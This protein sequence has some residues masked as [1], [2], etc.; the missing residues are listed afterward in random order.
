VLY[1]NGS[2]WVVNH[3]GTPTGTLDSTSFTG[4]V[5]DFSEGGIIKTRFFLNSEIFNTSNLVSVEG[6]SIKIRGMDYAS[7]GFVVKYHAGGNKIIEIMKDVN[8]QAGLNAFTDTIVFEKGTRLWK[9]ALCYEFSETVTFVYLGEGNTLAPNKAVANWAPFINTDVTAADVTKISNYNTEIRV[10]FTSGILKN[11]YYG[12]TILDASTG[13]PIING[14]EASIDSGYSYG[15]NH[16]LL[17][18]LNS[19]GQNSGDTLIIPAGSV[20][21][22]TQGSI[23]FTEEIRAVYTGDSNWTFDTNLGT[24]DVD[25]IA[26]V[27]NNGDTEVRVQIPLEFSDT[28]YG[29]LF[30]DGEAYVAK[31][32]DGSTVSAASLFWYGGQSTGY[33]N[34]DHSLIGF[35]GI[36]GETA[37]DQFI[38]PAGTKL[39]ILNGSGYHTFSEDVVYTFL[40]G[41]WK[42][43]DLI[44]TVKTTAEHATVE[45]PETDMFAGREYTFTVAPESGYVISTVTANG[46]ELALVDGK[47]TFTAKGGENNIVVTAKKLYTVTVN[48]GNATV[49]GI[50]NG[51]YADGTTVNFTVS[52]STGYHV[53]SVSGATGSN[54]S[55]TVT[56]SGD[57]TITVNTEIN[58]YT[59]TVSA[60]GASVSGVSNNQTITHGQTYTFTTSVN[61]GYQLTSVTINGVEQGTS[62]SYSFTANGATSIVVTTKKLYAVTWSN[63]T[64]ATISVTANGNTISSGTTVVEGTSISVSVAANSGYTVTNVTANGTSIG[65]TSGTYTVNG[66]TTIAATVKK[67]YTVTASTSGGV[68]V[69]ATSKTVVEGESATFTLTVPTDATI[70]ANGT[71]ISGTSYT[72]SNV[73][74]NTTV[75]FTTWYTVSVTSL[76]N[77]SVT[78]DGTS[79]SQGWSELRESGTSITVQASY[80]QSNSRSLKVGSNSWSDTSAH[81]VT[82]SGKTDISAS[83]SG[84]CIVEGTM[85]MMA[86]GTQK[87]VEDLV[88]GDMLLV[89]NHYTGKYDARPLAINAHADE[90]A[91][92]YKIVNVNFSNGTQWRIAGTHGI[93]D[94]T[95]NEYV[96]ISAENI[97]E[98]I[99]HEF[100]YT[101]GVAGE[102]VTLTDYYVTEE[103]VKIY[104]PATVEFANY[105]ANGLLNAPPFPATYT[106]GQMNYFDF[107]ENMMYMNVQEDIERYGLYTYEDF[108]DYIS[109][110]VF[111]A[112]PFKY[113]KI[114]VEKGIMAW[115]DVMAVIEML[116]A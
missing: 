100:Y 85:I 27:Y 69:D 99:G 59:V 18:I 74:A 58:T 1:F 29:S 73:T 110:D 5:I 90:D 104:S 28:Y 91:K 38:I 6:G 13:L 33:P 32:A 82:I 101:N 77:A 80:T 115:E 87:A 97:D 70:K 96:M 83:S 2:Y 57:T 108:A 17:G 93:F 22:T 35:R 67:T 40:N 26:G 39:F 68:S 10:Q 63:P 50:A 111:N 60:T 36:I 49:S 88:V 92:L 89:F 43:G 42:A 3:D 103:F 106:A 41:S 7:L 52:P 25:K 98:F 62:G 30:L 55:Y 11:T 105:F 19:Y 20:W 46:T 48:A 84:I 23:T 75:K 56:I 15:M 31:K 44:A 71:Q 45:L 54:G 81:T 9:D 109:E 76:S 78:V 95:L 21:W 34:Q 113:F 53:T 79:R 14:V 94:M 4:Q 24:I 8:T 12:N 16:N 47:Y 102:A 72:V 64:G 107:D 37:G 112:L 61:S 86:D 116:W 65:T 66:V 51:E 114:S